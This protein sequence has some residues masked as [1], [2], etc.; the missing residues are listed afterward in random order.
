M[1]EWQGR[2]VWVTGAAQGIGHA[3]ARTFAE[4]GASVVAFDL[5]LAEALPGNVKGVV[6]DV[7]D[8]EAVTRCCEQLLDEGLGPDV[9]VNVAGVLATGRLDEV[10]DALLQRTFAINTFAP[11][12]LMRALTPWFQGRRR[13]AIV[14]VSSNAG[15]V[16]RVGM[17]IYGAS[18][19]A[20]TSLTR[21][22][23]LELAP[24]G[25]RCNLV[26]PGSTR[27]PMLYGMWQEGEQREGEM[28]TI[29]GLPEQFKLGIPLGKLGAPDEV[30][31]CVLFLA[32][33]AASH[34]TLQ[35]LVVD[36]GATLGA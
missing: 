33:D 7:S 24:Y 15:R 21:T 30:A 20:L 3:V 32:S 9:L 23:G 19:A 10:D 16:P 27:T 8:S 11:F 29:A 2:T 25:V 12:Y 4:A 17:G 5:Q 18:K 35:D 36:G 14:N 31:A 28:R 1:S 34:I 6:I 26:S 13:G 22:A